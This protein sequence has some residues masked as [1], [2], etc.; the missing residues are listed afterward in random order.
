[1]KSWQLI[2]ALDEAGDGLLFVSDPHNVMT[3]LILVL[4]FCCGGFSAM[5]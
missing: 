1:M 3:A 2:T 4:C 5:P